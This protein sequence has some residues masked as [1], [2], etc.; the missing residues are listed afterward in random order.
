[1]ADPAGPGVPDLI[2]R[3]ASEDAFERREA[4]QELERR[5]HRDF[6]FRWSAPPEARA[7]AVERWRAWWRKEHK[8]ARRGGKIPSKAVEIGGALIGL[9]QL[10][11][12]LKGIPPEQ[13][14][15]H[16]AQILQKMQEAEAA[17]SQCEKCGATRATVHV[18]EK[19]EGGI[20]REQNLCEEC[21]KRQGELPG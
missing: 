4:Q 3:L 12:A 15:A 20:L 16:L 17:R 1:V 6:G 8:G 19:D 14:E 10:K 7:R 11:N 13:L 18:T 2:E 5:T 21:A 9:D